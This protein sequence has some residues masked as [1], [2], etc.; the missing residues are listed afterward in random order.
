MA[1]SNPITDVLASLDQLEAKSR[2]AKTYF[3]TEKAKLVA[4]LKAH[5][6]AHQAEV[7]AVRTALA[8]LGAEIEP[9]EKDVAKFVLTTTS[10][11][12]RFCLK[13]GR[14]A[15]LVVFVAGCAGVARFLH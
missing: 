6:D 9:A 10:S 2:Q 15:L 14:W 12:E 13:Y 3:E 8:K 5:A 1:D 11:F 7:D 4:K